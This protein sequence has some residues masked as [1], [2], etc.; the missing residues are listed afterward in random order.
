MTNNTN[1]TT[2]RDKMRRL[3]AGQPDRTLVETMLTVDH[4]MNGLQRGSDEWRAQYVVRLA[5]IEELESRYDVDAAMERWADEATGD[6]TYVEALLVAL[7]VEV[8]R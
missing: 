1:T 7:P 6:T 8:T 3:I 2:A 4:T 5:V